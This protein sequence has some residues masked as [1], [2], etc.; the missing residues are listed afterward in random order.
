LPSPELLRSGVMAGRA[1]V[2]VDGSGCDVVGYAAVDV[3]GCRVLGGVGK[4]SLIYWDLAMC[5]MFWRR[6]A[7]GWRRREWRVSLCQLKWVVCW[8]ICC[9]FFDA[10]VFRSV[11]SSLSVSWAKRSRIQLEICR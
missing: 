5:S 7:P 6:P 2:F 4:D 9:T 10:S 3:C 8:I 1:M 11:S